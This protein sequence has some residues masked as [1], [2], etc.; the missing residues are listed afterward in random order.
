[1]LLPI[2][3]R[4]KLIDHIR[5]T[6]DRYDVDQDANTTEVRDWKLG[7]IF[8]SNAVVVG[9]PSRFFED[10]G[11]S[12]TGGF[13]ETNKNRAKVILVGANDGMLHAFDASTGDEKWGFIPNSLLNSLKLM[14]STHTF[15]VDSS[16]K[17][18]DVWFYESSTDR[19]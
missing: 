7:D 18:A 1:M 11:F 10:Q 6:F 8:H 13:Y 3:D 5:G 4:Q 9:E 2:S 15:Y 17:V 19:N 14:G 16:P 12:G